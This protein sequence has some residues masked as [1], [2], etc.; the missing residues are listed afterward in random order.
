MLASDR[1]HRRGF[2]SLLLGLAGP[3]TL[4]ARADEVI[5]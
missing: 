3:L 2:V 4:L 5:E 1:T